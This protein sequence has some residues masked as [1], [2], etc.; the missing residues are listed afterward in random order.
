MKNNR[1]FYSLILLLVLFGCGKSEV[2]KCVDAKLIQIVSEIC[3]DSKDINISCK[4]YEEKNIQSARKLHEGDVRDECLR[5]Q[6][7][8]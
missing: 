7:G 2:D 5:A 3:I 8:K 4:E 6:A 1:Y